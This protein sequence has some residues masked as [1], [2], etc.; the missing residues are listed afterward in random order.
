MNRSRSTGVLLVGF[1]RGSR[2]LPFPELLYN[3][4]V[5]FYSSDLL[6]LRRDY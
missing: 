5:D 6:L 2:G 1:G 4:Q 3:Y